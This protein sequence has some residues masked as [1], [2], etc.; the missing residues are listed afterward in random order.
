MNYDFYASKIDK[1][2]LLNYLFEETDLCVYELYSELGT[3]VC[4]YT[5]ATGIDSKFDLDNGGLYAVTFQLWSPRF[6]VAPDFVRVALNPHS[7]E[8]HTFRY[9]TS[10]LGLIQLYFG[11]QQNNVLAYSHIGHFNEKG[12]LAQADAD[13]H[14]MGQA[15]CWNW[16][17]INKTSR[18]LKYLLHNKWAVKKLGSIGVLPGAAQLEQKGIG[19]SR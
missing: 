12:V 5:N 18:K 6:V 13:T 19:L 11:G 9:R 4:Q 17:E 15:A 3:E 2:S 16:T 10:G 7:C 8:G 14:G 1:L